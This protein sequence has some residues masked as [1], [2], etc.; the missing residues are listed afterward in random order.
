[1]KPT[2]LN[3]YALK[4]R[5]VFR[6]LFLECF[7]KE[8]ERLLSMGFLGDAVSV[9]RENIVDLMNTPALRSEILNKV[10]RAPKKSDIKQIRAYA[11]GTIRD[12]FLDTEA[13]RVIPV[14]Q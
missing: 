3:Q 14:E 12:L 6:E 11:G 2:K 13:Y 10:G 5:R 7:R 1:M 8:L 4:Y 9:A